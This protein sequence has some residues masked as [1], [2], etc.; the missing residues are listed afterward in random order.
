MQ[1][2]RP[3]LWFD[4]KA[5]EAVQFYASIFRNSKVTGVVRH[6]D[7][8]PGPEHSVLGV[9]FQLEGREFIA[10]NGGPQY[11]FTPAV[12]FFVTCET[13][14]EIDWYWDRLCEGG[15]PV[16]CGWLKDKYGLSWQIVPA[17]LEAML[18]DK[19]S[20]KA[21]RVMQALMHMVKFDIAGL[22]R[23]YDAG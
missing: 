14:E 11:S 5:E 9:N 17:M 22:Q 20:A 15:E 19:D 12:S 21:S 7:A 16:Q 3:F 13:Q 10:L 8:G 23:A 1:K 2:I 18:R 4:G 6:T